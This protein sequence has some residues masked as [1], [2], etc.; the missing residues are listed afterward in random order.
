MNSFLGVIH[1]KAKAAKYNDATT[2]GETE[3]K[4]IPAEKEREFDAVRIASAC[5]VDWKPSIPTY[6]PFRPNYNRFTI[7]FV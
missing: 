5:F 7:E 6:R 3:S 2:E 1:N 4:K